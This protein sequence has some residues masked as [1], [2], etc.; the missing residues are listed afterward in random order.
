MWLHIVLGEGPLNRL[1]ILL[2]QIGEEI[3]WC[4]YRKGVSVDGRDLELFAIAV[5]IC[6]VSHKIKAGI[7]THTQ[8]TSTLCRDHILCIV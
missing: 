7:V 6:S 1:A 5:R 4:I 2:G 3:G 8:A